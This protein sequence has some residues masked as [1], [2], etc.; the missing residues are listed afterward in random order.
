ML[1]NRVNNEGVQT[2]LYSARAYTA[3]GGANEKRLRW[4]Q[5]HGNGHRRVRTSVDSR[6]GCVQLGVDSLYVRACGHECLG[7]EYRQMGADG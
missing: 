2:G 6:R 4:A 3:M 1:K 7:L 5:T